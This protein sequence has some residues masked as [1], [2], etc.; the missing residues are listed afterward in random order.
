MERK[1]KTARF[2]SLVVVFDF[3]SHARKTQHRRNAIEPISTAA[4]LSFFWQNTAR[5]FVVAVPQ[6][7]RE[8]CSS[9]KKSGLR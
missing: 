6:E 5:A 8:T 2:P 9:S 7:L 3:L 1:K 4:M